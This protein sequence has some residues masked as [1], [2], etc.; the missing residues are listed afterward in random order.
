MMKRKSSLM[1]TRKAAVFAS[2]SFCPLTSEM[3]PQ[4]Q[5]TSALLHT[6]GD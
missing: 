2:A 5:I 1:Q 6:T 3:K 4:N